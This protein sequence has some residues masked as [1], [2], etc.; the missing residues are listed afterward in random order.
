[1]LPP[2][3]GRPRGTTS[4]DRRYSPPVVATYARISRK[5]WRACKRTGYRHPT[6]TPNAPDAEDG[7]LTLNN[8]DGMHKIST[9]CNSSFPRSPF[10][11]PFLFRWLSFRSPY[12]FLSL[13]LFSLELHT[14]KSTW[15]GKISTRA[16]NRRPNVTVSTPRRGA[17]LL[18][19][20][21][22]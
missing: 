8:T 17:A 14:C 7:S 2:A 10:L 1:M 3:G 11:S 9:P 5:L 16:S 21:F 18:S 4:N 20:P 15:A 22:Q 19:R 12:L 13:A 6:N